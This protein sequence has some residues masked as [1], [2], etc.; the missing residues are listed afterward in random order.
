MKRRNFIE[1]GALGA[2]AIGGSSTLKA[3]EVRWQ[4]QEGFLTE[5]TRDV[6]IAGEYDVVVCGSGPA[7]VSAAIEAGR[8]GAKTLLLEVHGCLGGIWTSGNLAWIL[9]NKNKSGILKE[10][11]KR[12]TG[13]NANSPIE[14]GSSFAFDVEKMKLLLEI[15]CAEAKVDIQ[16]FSRV[17]ASAKNEGHRL[18]H[19]LTESKSG[20]QAWAAK[21]FIDA[22][23]DG[24]LAALSGCGFDVGDRQGNLQPMSMLAV[25]GG[26]HY[27]EI[28]AFVRRKADLAHRSKGFL[29]A[30]MARAGIVPSYTRPG[31]YPIREDLYMIMT[32]HQY[33]VKGFNAA[34]VTRATLEARRELHQIIDGLR[35]LGDI[36][37]DL[38]IIATAEQ[39]GVREGR[40]IHGLYTVT[41]QD[42]IDGRR[43]DDGICRVAFGVDVHSVVKSDD[44]DMKSYSRKIRS[45]PYD[46]PLRALIARDVQG[47]LMAG[48]CISG[49][50]IAHSSYRV[51]G[52]ASTMGQA[53]GKCAAVAAMTNRLPQ[54][55]P[56]EELEL[57]YSS[58]E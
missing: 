16:L 38:N 30:E 28:K 35:S 33:G 12:L 5:P 32:N 23:G 47:L 42:L 7:G 13:M 17:V 18:T 46:I 8:T 39:I 22:T 29:L 57:G 10:I 31:L 21:V 50:F 58:N 34:D 48:R 27:T 1:I 54:M 20:R 55:V 40:R 52:D 49:D 36:W 51:T 9:D 26:V 24:D 15:M 19:V 45:K 3:H 44:L 43:H 37:Q 41:Q 4:N 2:F 11:M 56:F 53:A 25:I 14:T 6:P